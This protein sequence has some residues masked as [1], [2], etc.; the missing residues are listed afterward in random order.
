[1]THLYTTA[2]TTDAAQV[3]CWCEGSYCSIR[4]ASFEPHHFKLQVPDPTHLCTHHG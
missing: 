2:H 3:L 1:M 4:T